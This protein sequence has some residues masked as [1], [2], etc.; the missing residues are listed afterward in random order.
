[1]IVGNKHRAPSVQAFLP[2]RLPLC[3]LNR[4]VLMV[5][6]VADDHSFNALEEMF[7]RFEAHGN[8]HWQ[9]KA[10]AFCIQCF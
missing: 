8:R 3:V 10:F 6:S 1:M 5:D 7:S 9:T 4:A 2:L